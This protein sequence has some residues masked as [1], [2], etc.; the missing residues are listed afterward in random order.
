MQ[1]KNV[2]LFGSFL[3]SSAGEEVGL[4]AVTPSAQIEGELLKLLSETRQPVD[5]KTLVTGTSGSA[6]ETLKI[7]DDMARFKL[8][9]KRSDG[10]FNITDLGND[11][12]AG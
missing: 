5:L 7:L 4:P 11:L 6:T 9:E 8:I 3:S 2:D 10:T 12:T 1:T